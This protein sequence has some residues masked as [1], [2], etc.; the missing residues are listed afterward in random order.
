MDWKKILIVAL[1]ILI[2]VY[3][4]LAVTAF[5][6]PAAKAA[7]CSEVKIDIDDN[8]SAGFLD[9]REVK[10]LLERQRLYPL[11]KSM[12][13][14]S[15]RD[16]EETLRLNPFVER[17]EC[18]KAQGGLVCI[19]L[20]QRSPVAHVKA[21]SGDSY[22]LDNHGNILPETKYAANLIVAS[23]WISRRYAQ[24][25]L[26]PMARYIMDDKFWQSQIEQVYVRFDGSVELVPRVG[27]HIVY[28]G[29]P[30]DIV[31]KLDRL[32]KFYL[33]GLSK[34]GWNKYSL[35]NIEFD[36]QIICKKRPRRNA[37]E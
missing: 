19:T 30:V 8:Q 3:L 28:L 27:S 1:D 35:I 32:R 20:Q 36:N 6:R 22:Y 29:Q 23:G 34:A 21:N 31:R 9:T 4:L 5:N 12:E 14:V 15:P 16:I 24:K 13:Q 33:Y 25:T 37:N 7:V 2:A 26:A 18:Y 17:A 10:L 11:A